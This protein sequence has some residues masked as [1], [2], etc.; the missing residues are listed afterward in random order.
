MKHLEAQH[1]AAIPLWR[2]V[3]KHVDNERHHDGAEEGFFKADAVNEEDP[4]RDCAT[5]V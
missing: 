1:R 3:D 4:E 5:Q 2:V